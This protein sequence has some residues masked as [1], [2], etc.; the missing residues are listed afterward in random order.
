M[1][2]SSNLE[3]PFLPFSNGTFEVGVVDSELLNDYG[4][5]LKTQKNFKAERL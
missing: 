1:H 4:V 2:T 3:W 5:Y